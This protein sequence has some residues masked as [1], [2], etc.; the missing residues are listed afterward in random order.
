ML[1]FA[2]ELRHAW[3]SLLQRKAYFFT[4]AA[5]LTLVL[6][7]NAA[8]FAVVNATLLRPMPFT[9]KGEV[10]QLFD[11]PPGTTDAL[12]RNPL[13]QMEVSRLRS[14][15]RTLARI[16]G[17]LLSERVVTRNGQPGVSQSAA[18]TPGL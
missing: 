17:F 13:Q 2:M 3:R 12:Q 16:E 15:A 6:G 5:T 1:T 11:Q 9:T 4:C 10:L 14:T 7:A 18:V 8:I